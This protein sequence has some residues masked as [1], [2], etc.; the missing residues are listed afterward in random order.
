MRDFLSAELDYEAA[1][2]LVTCCVVP[3]PIAWVVSLSPAGTVNVAPFSCFTY[4]A[5]LPP[6]IGVSVG[7]RGGRPKDT[8]AN[9]RATRHFT[10]N[11]ASEAQL[12]L[13]EASAA[14]FGP[15]ESESASLDIALAPGRTIPVPRI[16]AAPIALECL[17]DRVI[18]MGDPNGH[19]FFIGKVQCIRVN[20]EVVADNAVDPKRL[21]PLA[22][23]GRGRYASVGALL[24]PKKRSRFI[25]SSGKASE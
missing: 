18:E 14:E 1:Y 12:D 25:L 9:I 5:P 8:A 2:R 23:L 19:Q 3:R 24:E 15:E 11:V 4:L 20:P 16:E 7:T 6:M 13:L 10:V 22:R 21:R 17:L